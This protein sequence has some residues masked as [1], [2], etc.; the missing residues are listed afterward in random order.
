MQEDALRFTLR[1]TSPRALLVAVVVMIS[2]GCK[3]PS[4]SGPTVANAT[5]TTGSTTSTSA[6]ATATAAAT[7]A[8]TATAPAAQADAGSEAANAPTATNVVID[9]SPRLPLAI[10]VPACAKLSGP[11]VKIA[12]N[13]SD[14]ILMC[15][16]SEQ[17]EMDGKQAFAVQVGPAQGKLGKKEIAKDINFVRFT[18][19]TKD[20]LEFETKFFQDVRADFI[21]RVTQKSKEYACFPVSG[22]TDSALLAREKAACLSLKSK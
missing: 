4:K 15:S 20:Q 18:K 6:T 5:S 14:A 2:A 1:P 11:L 8:A 13:A 16:I 3:P 10:T 9:L 21:Y 22:T 19:A 12:D 7:A 17:E